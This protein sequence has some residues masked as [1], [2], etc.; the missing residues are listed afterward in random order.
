MH[1]GHTPQRHL[2]HPETG[3]PALQSM[4]Q[5]MLLY[6]DASA[7]SVLKDSQLAGEWQPTRSSWS[8][9]RTFIL[10]AAWIRNVYSNK[11]GRDPNAWAC[12]QK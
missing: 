8:G 11:V 1:K 5:V 12:C 6:T 2:L 7:R 10:G 4:I 9:G 3:L